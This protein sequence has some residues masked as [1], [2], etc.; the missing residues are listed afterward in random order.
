MNGSQL[1]HFFTLFFSHSF[2]PYLY[3]EETTKEKNKIHRLQCIILFLSYIYIYIVFPLNIYGIEE[4]KKKK[5]KKSAF[6]PIKAFLPESRVVVLLFF[7]FW[8]GF[9]CRFSATCFVNLLQRRLGNY[10]KKEKK[11]TVVGYSIFSMWE[12]RS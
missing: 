7:F 4:R 10:D 2:L 6:H 8:G 12:Q 3:L 9:V 1:Q 5:K 11:R